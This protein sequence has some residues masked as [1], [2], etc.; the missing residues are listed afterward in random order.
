MIVYATRSGEKGRYLSIATAQPP[1]V[2]FACDPFYAAPGINSKRSSRDGADPMVISLTSAT[3]GL[4]AR[5]SRLYRDQQKA[6]GARSRAELA[7][8]TRGQ[9][10]QIPAYGPLR[11]HPRGRTRYA[12]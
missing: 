5:G 10:G 8:E 12:R 2:T 9:I 6:Q 1:T 11:A 7:R 4:R 3:A